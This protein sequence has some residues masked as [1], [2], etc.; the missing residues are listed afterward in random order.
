L[1]QRYSPR[2]ILAGF[3]L[4]ASGFNHNLVEH[5]RFTLFGD[6]IVKE[7]DDLVAPHHECIDLALGE[8]SSD[9]LLDLVSIQFAQPLQEL[10]IALPGYGQ[11]F[12]LSQVFVNTKCP[13]KSIIHRC[14]FS[15]IR[16]FVRLGSVS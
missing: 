15:E 7:G 14:Q 8:V 4:P 11:V 13:L 16:T 1:E 6:Q 3:W 12:G 9:L 2:R 10:T 5:C